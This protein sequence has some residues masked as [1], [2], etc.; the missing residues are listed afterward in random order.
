MK[1]T[2]RRLESVFDV[3]ASWHSV[4]W[5]HCVISSKEHGHVS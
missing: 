1:K 3:P 2:V 4:A 5:I